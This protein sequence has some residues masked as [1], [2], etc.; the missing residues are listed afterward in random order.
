MANKSKIVADDWLDPINRLIFREAVDRR[1][2][3][4]RLR[5]G[6]TF[7]LTYGTKTSRLLTEPVEIV[8]MVPLKPKTLVPRGTFPVNE[9]LD[10]FFLAP[11]DAPKSGRV[12][13]NS[14]V[15]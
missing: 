10:P 11:K 6:R 13:G 14:E 3:T 9:I 2:P 1:L 15:Q 4:L 7:T 12:Y 8:T 5:D